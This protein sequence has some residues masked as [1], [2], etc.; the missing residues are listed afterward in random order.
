MI[1]IVLCADEGYAPYAAVVMA[2]VLANAEN[3]R[4][5]CFFLLTAGIQ[6][7]TAR[8][9]KE[10][11]KLHDAGITIVEADTSALRG[12]QTRRFGAAALLRLFLHEYLPERCQRAIYLDCDVMV[13]TDLETLWSMPLDRHVAAAAMD[14]TSKPRDGAS[15]SADDYFNS[16]VM[17]IDLTAWQSRQI[18]EK[19]LACLHEKGETFRYPD[20]DAL[21]KTLAGAWMRLDPRWNFQPTAYAAVEKRYSH[22]AAH[23]PALEEAIKQPCIV[24][25]IGATKP[26]HGMCVHPLKNEFFFYSQQTPW[27]LSR[28][29]M[30]AQLSWAK[31]LRLA[32]RGFKTRRRQS[33]TR[34]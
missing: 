14:L 24:H 27:P 13:R 4:R 6:P 12:I 10:F 26:W 20:Q 7:L 5:L 2:S 8:R 30:L 22:L 25:F 16:G 33:M 3:P 17:L 23:L 31:R 11:V 29:S 1:N 15:G 21:N 19:A 32:G 34:F 18:G 9:L 28:G